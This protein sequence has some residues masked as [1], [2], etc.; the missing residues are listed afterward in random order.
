[1]RTS[2]LPAVTDFNVSNWM[3]FSFP[4]W[5]QNLTVQMVPKFSVSSQEES[6]E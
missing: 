6:K 2:L 1:M 4:H 5:L 3:D